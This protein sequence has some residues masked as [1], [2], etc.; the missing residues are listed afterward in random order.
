MESKDL[1]LFL[2]AL[3]IRPLM[4]PEGVSDRV[5][6]RGF[7]TISKC[8]R[9]SA[10]PFPSSG[11]MADEGST[12]AEGATSSQ[13]LQQR[14]FVPIVAVKMWES[15]KTKKEKTEAESN[16]LPY[17]EVRHQKLGANESNLSPS[18]G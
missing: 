12:G 17:A 18:A 7:S 14:L 16:V 9:T 11:R 15:E 2:V 4:I 5:S 6:R 8:A 3:W 10:T 13:L 1:D